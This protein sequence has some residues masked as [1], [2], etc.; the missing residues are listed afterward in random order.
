MTVPY[1][2]SLSGMGDQLLE[3]FNI[4]WTNDK[5]KIIIPAKYARNNQNF[6]IE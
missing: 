3:H 5:S 6:E 4:E 1:N 2:I